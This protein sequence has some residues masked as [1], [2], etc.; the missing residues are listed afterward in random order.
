MGQHSISLDLWLMAR[1]I[2]RVA[3]MT[4]I[5]PG[6]AFNFFVYKFGTG[7]H[8]P[9]QS[10]RGQILG[11]N[12]RFLSDFFSAGSKNFRVSGQLAHTASVYCQQ[13]L[14]TGQQA[15]PRKVSAA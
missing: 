3:V 7:A 14:S 10:E 5:A 11:S 12:P 4:G 9:A 13:R 15:P 2:A 1:A 8:R 6:I